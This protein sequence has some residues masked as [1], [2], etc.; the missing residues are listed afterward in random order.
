MSFAT[1]PGGSW[2]D[3]R[4]VGHD[5]LRNFLCDLLGPTAI[6]GRPNPVGSVA[7]I[8]AMGSLTLGLTVMWWTMPRLLTGRSLGLTIRACGALSLLGLVAVPLTP[9]TLSYPLH[10]AAVFTGGIPGAAAWLLAL[11]GLAREARTR[12][13]ASLGA[14]ALAFMTVGFALYSF[15]YFGGGGPTLLLPV[16]HRI[17]TVFFL[18]WVVAV[19]LQLKKATGCWSSA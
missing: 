1:Y 5:L 12:R 4:A 11:F 2:L 13:L 17:A 14:L 15:Q 9:P 7:M 10:A 8:L 18:G 19:A 3:R 6:N 16:S